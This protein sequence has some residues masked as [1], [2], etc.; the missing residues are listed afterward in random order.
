MLDLHDRLAFAASTHPAS[1]DRDDMLEL[2]E[3]AGLGGSHVHDLIAA[4]P[5]GHIVMD[6]AG[7][8]EAMRLARTKGRQATPDAAPGPFR[9]A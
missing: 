8:R 6:R 9:Q 7:L 2:L 5:P 3:Q 1:I 4:H